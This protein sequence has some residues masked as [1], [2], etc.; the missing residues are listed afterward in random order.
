MTAEPIRSTRA[1]AS[2]D[3][4]PSRRVAGT[5]RVVVAGDVPPGATAVAVPVGTD[6]EVPA[7]LGL[8][9]A[10]LASAGFA[11]TVGQAMPFPG[12]AVPELVALG[13]GD[14]AA[15]TT[16]S[17]RDAAAAFARA[18]YRHASIAVAL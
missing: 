9:R 6:G 14:P 3:P 12:D 17:L 7:R 11:G 18:T 8:S 16:A 13:V 10:A 15:F 1:N 4:I 5:Q 2:F